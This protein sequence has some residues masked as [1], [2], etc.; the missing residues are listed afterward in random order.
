[1]ANLADKRQMI[2]EGKL[3]VAPEGYLDDRPAGKRRRGGKG[4]KGAPIGP[5]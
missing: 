3:K 2:A 1:M 4:K 5:M